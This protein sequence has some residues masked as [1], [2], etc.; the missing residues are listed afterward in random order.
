MSLFPLLSETIICYG[1]SFRLLRIFRLD[2]CFHFFSVLWEQTRS[3]YI[4]SIE[5]YTTSHYTTL[6][7][8]ALHYITL[9]FTP[10]I[11]LFYFQ[12]MLD[13]ARAMQYNTIHVSIID[14]RIYFI[15]YF[16]IITSYQSLFGTHIMHFFSWWS[17]ETTNVSILPLYHIL[18]DTSTIY[19]SHITI[20][21]TF[22]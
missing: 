13:T 3:Q 5:H 4:G 7:H 12:L 11:I 2:L 20:S 1:H 10:F 22:W 17:H 18:T 21:H 9:H 14:S 19:A 6:Y 16:L 15:T 8:T